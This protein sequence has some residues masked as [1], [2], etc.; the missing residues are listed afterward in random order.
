MYNSLFST[1]AKVCMYYIMFCCIMRCLL[2]TT[3]Y[4]NL[5]THS[6]SSHNSSQL[7]NQ[8]PW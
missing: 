3:A 8:R 2:Y 4:N 1:N 7:D 6:W 5:Y